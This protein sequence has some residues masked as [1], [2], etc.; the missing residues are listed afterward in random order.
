MRYNKNYDERLTMTDQQLLTFFVGIITLCMLVITAVVVFI[1]IQMVKSMN[2]VHEFI[3]HV[4]NELNFL[5]TKAV[6]TLHDVSELLNHLKDETHTIGEKSV[7]VLHEVR[8]LITYIQDEIRSLA[9]SASNGIAKVTVGT[10]AIRALS[11]FFK[12][13]ANS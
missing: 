12:K 2:K 3:A 5:S 7:L 6:V 9:F 8:D 11:Q 13:K 1:S 10:L 4:Q